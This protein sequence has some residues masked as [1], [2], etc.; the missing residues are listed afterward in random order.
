MHDGWIAAACMLGVCACAA[1]IIHATRRVESTNQPPR[2][3]P[4]DMSKYEDREWE[5]DKVENIKQQVMERE[6][7]KEIYINPSQYAKLDRAFQDKYIRLGSQPRC[8]SGTT[9]P[10]FKK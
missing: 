2:T 1:R 9:T 3:T 6:S 8:R 7:G 4:A 10:Y 5:S